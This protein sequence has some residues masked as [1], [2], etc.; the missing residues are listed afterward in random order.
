MNR[1]LVLMLVSLALAVPARGVLA[2]SE[3]DVRPREPRGFDF[4]PD[5]VWRLRARRV[6][7]A[8]AAALSRRDFRALNA[9]MAIRA[10]APSAM[11]VTGVLRAPAIHFSFADVS[12]ASLRDTSLYTG[13]L[14]APVAAGRPYT[15]RTFYEEMSNGAFSLQGTVLGWVTLSGNESSYVGPSSGCSPYGTC[16]GIWSS[17]AFAALQSGLTQA[18]QAVDPSVNF[19]LYDNDGPD[20]QPN[21]GD[22][23]G[24]VDMTIFI[25]S[26]PDGACRSIANNNHPWSHRFSINAT[27]NDPRADSPGQFIRVTNYIVQS[28][29]GGATGCD[30]TQ[31]MGIGTVAHEMGHG[32]GLDDLY[33]TNP[34]DGDD[35]E[36]VGHWG[37]M[38][39]GGYA[40]AASPSYLE[41]F[42]RN[43]LGWITVRQLTTGG[44][45]S[46]GPTTGKDTVFLVRPTA[47]NPGGEYFLLENRQAVL[48]DTALIRLKG[49]GLLIWHVDSTKYAQSFFLNEV[50]SGPIHAV[51]LR[52]ADS[53]DQLR[54]STPGVRNRGDA[55]DPFPGTANN[56]VFGAATNPSSNLNTGLPS[57]IE[58]D[59]IR[60][61]TPGGAIAFRLLIGSEVRASVAS[62]MVKVNDTAYTVFRRIAQRTETLSVSIDSVQTTNGG[63]TQYEYRS[64]SDG[65]ARSHTV[66]VTPASPL[67]LIAQMAEF[68]RVTLSTVGNGTVT[69]TPN[70]G[71]GGSVMVRSADTLR[72]VASP[73]PQNLFESWSGDVSS[74]YPSL[75]IPVTRPLTLTATFVPLLLDS[76]VAQLLRG[77]GLTDAQQSLMDLQTNNNG[78]FDLGDFVAWLDR[79]GTTVSA[80]VMARV[81]G[82]LRR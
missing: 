16:N 58:V 72:L 7:E 63:S 4:T 13:V 57:G 52:Q 15:V 49:P 66:I 32:L 1:R 8:R 17:A 22:D 79:S 41:S 29:L 33:D 40:T 69:S 35:S 38:G 70:L 75:N 74:V 30:A 68:N 43:E 20:T 42:S 37:L 60:Q 39:S 6:Q 9:P 59:S 14:F 36:G 53:L 80:E 73:V 12:P 25:H 81:L 23:D 5:G 61:V 76:A 56:T 48:S 27:T 67:I 71:P 34:D 28:G 64:W 19:G 78:V 11:A 18:V 44:T 50:N 62:A 31:I 3:Q 21:S 2:Q 55:G 46:L 77:S 24:Q 47:S 26:V 65:G 54:S 82:R 45:Y 10:L 51:W